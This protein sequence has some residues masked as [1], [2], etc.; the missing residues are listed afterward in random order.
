MDP[1]FPGLGK[2]FVVRK[3]GGDEVTKEDLM[4]RAGSLLEEF[5]S[6][7][8]KRK[9]NNPAL[10]LSL[11][12]PTFLRDD[13]GQVILMPGGGISIQPVNRS[14]IRATLN[15]DQKAISV[16]KGPFDLTVGYGIAPGPK[17]VGVPADPT[18]KSFVYRP[19]EYWARLGFEFGR[20]QGMSEDSQPQ[21]IEPSKEL[22]PKSAAREEYEAM[23]GPDLSGYVPPEEESAARRF[24]NDRLRQL[25]QEI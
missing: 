9:I 12:V 16:G 11:G 7:V 15:A 24:L 2:N 8:Q 10:G 21:E 6:E 23:F 17:G 14:A 13:T 3:E 25:R 19:H 4:R 1:Q 18:H 5:A 20:G 22:T